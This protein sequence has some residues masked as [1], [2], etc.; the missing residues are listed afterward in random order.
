MYSIITW[1]IESWTVIR[2]M[3]FNAK[4]KETDK[5]K[6]TFLHMNKNNQVM[7]SY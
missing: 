7:V 5:F 4:I 2:D 3:Y 1:G 6:I